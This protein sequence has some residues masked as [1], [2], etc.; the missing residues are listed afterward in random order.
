MSEGHRGYA[1][2]PSLTRRVVILRCQ[3]LYQRIQF[4]LA[5]N[6]LN[7]TNP[8][9]I[10][11]FITRR[12]SEGHRGYAPCPSLTRRVVILRCQCLY[13]RIQ[14]L[15]AQNWLNKTNPIAINVFITRRVSEGHRGYAPCP[16]LTRRVVI[17]RCQYLY[18]RIQFLLAQNWLNKTSPI[19]INVFITRRVSEGHRGCSLCPSLTRR[20]VI[21]RCQCLYQRIQFLLAQNWL[22][23]TNPIAINVFITRRGCEFFSRTNSERVSCLLFLVFCRIRFDWASVCFVASCFS[24]YDRALPVIHFVHAHPL[25]TPSFFILMKLNVIAYHKLDVSALIRPR[26]RNW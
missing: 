8:I 20:V 6:W 18:Q 16:S 19:A 17:L 4:L 26:T 25:R 12:V 3:C 5:Q 24:T 22:N 7:K 9:A 23:K 21:L 11:V 10:N 13:Q 14:F 1:P 15:L 2:C